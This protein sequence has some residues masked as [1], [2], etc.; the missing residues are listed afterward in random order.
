MCCA[1]NLSERPRATRKVSPSLEFLSISLL[2]LCKLSSV[3]L[4]LLERRARCD[5]PKIYFEYMCVAETKRIKWPQML[6]RESARGMR[7]RLLQPIASLPHGLFSAP[8]ENT[9]RNNG[10]QL[11]GAHNVTPPTV[12]RV[13]SKYSICRP[14]PGERGWHELLF[15]CAKL[16]SSGRRV[17][18]CRLPWLETRSTVSMTTS[19][20]NGEVLTRQHGTRLQIRQA[21][22]S[23]SP[24]SESAR[25]ETGDLRAKNGYLRAMRRGKRSFRRGRRS[26]ERAR[27]RDW[28]ITGGQVQRGGPSGAGVAYVETVHA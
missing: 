6:R 17:E 19:T 10:R 15:S 4:F 8:G 1:R 22:L 5:G 12:L 28:I 21:G 7:S 20:T 26:L 2:S 13:E 24:R 18:D 11:L 3:Q 14:L 25:H 9:V 23:N 16:S 27:M